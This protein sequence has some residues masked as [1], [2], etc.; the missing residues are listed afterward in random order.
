[1]EGNQNPSDVWTGS[2][3]QGSVPTLTT[4]E[5]KTAGNFAAKTY[6]ADYT[7]RI[8]SQLQ[9]LHANRRAAPRA[10]LHVCRRAPTQAAE[11]EE[12]K[13]LQTFSGEARKIRNEAGRNN[14]MTAS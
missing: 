14:G 11:H 4:V 6:Q 9:C 12:L 2:G 5:V 8:L 10:S 3:Q 1:M 7:M 13:Q